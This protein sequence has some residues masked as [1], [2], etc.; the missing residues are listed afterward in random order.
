MK[1]EITNV[2]EEIITG[3]GV[4]SSSKN[5]NRSGGKKKTKHERKERGI[6]KEN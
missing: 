6:N 1:V 5:R 2:H 4:S 3:K